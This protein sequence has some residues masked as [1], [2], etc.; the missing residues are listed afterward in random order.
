MTDT[1][2]ALF[3]SAVQ[4]HRK[5]TAIIENGRIM[6]FGELS[7]L[8]DMIAGSFPEEISSIRLAENLTEFMI[9]E[10]IVKMPQIPLNTNGK[11]DMAKLP[12]VMKE[13]NC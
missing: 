5:E 8:V 7:N 11:P 10:F 12:V 3:Q 9:P 6:T 2:Y 4:N 13:G 1:I